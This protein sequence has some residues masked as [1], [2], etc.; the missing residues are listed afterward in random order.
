MGEPHENRPVESWLSRPVNPLGKDAIHLQ[1]HVRNA[2]RER[3]QARLLCYDGVAIEVG[4]VGRRGWL[5]ISTC[6]DEY[7]EAPDDR[8]QPDERQRLSL[9]RLGGPLA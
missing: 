9:P 1:D 4:I 6:N 5:L 7:R 2:F 3:D 8:K